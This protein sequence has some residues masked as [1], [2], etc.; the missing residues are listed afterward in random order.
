MGLQSRTDLSK[1]YFSFFYIVYYLKLVLLV[2]RG[3]NDQMQ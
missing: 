3:Q 1:K 2:S